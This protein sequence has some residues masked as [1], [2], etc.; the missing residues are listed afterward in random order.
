[1]AK[2][3]SE[4][5]KGE[6]SGTDELLHGVYQLFVGRSISQRLRNAWIRAEEDPTA[7]TASTKMTPDNSFSQV[8]EHRWSGTRATPSN[9]AQGALE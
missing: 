8:T 6:R 7:Q 3:G 4:R 9:E 2:D 1:M 5:N